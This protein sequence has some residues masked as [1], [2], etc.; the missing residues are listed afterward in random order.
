MGHVYEAQHEVLGRPVAIKLLHRRTAEHVDRFFAEARIAASIRHPGIVDVFDIGVASDGSPYIVMELL[1]GVDLATALIRKKRMSEAEAVELAI[2]TAKA[3]A[4]A[5]AR[6]VV[7]RDLKPENIFLTRARGQSTQVT[8]LDFG[9]AKARGH[10]V[11]V[12]GQV[13]GTPQYMA[14]EQHFGSAQ[15]DHRA[16]IYALGCILYEMLVGRPPFIGL[17]AEVMAKHQHA[18]PRL[19]SQ[20]GATVSDRLERLLMRMLAKHP[21]DR[22]AN[23]GEVLRKLAPLRRDR[24]R[25]RSS[26]RYGW[27]FAASRIALGVVAGLAITALVGGWMKA[28]ASA[29]DASPPATARLVDGE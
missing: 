3:L 12:A 1:D 16:D 29:P 23:I 17:G 27:R 19:P 22:P 10:V 8:I 24:R 20:I 4:A 9:V 18:R 21:D 14:P 13:L 6:G 28:E 2:Q 5:H 26:E 7:H 15:V 25:R 11:T